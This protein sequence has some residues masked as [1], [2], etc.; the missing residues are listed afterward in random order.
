MV[1]ENL[2]EIVVCPKCKQKLSYVQDPEQF[3]CSTCKKSYP[4]KDGIP[5]LIMEE[6]KDL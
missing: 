2:K 5:I 4:V 3:N 1:N 6:A